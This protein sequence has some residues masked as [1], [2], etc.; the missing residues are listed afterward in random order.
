MANPSRRE[1]SEVRRVGLSAIS[2]RGHFCRS[3]G[4]PGDLPAFLVKSRRLILARLLNVKV[5]GDVQRH[6]R[7]T[8]ATQAF[9]NADRPERTKPRE[10]G[11]FQLRGGCVDL[12]ICLF[13]KKVKSRRLILAR[14]WNVKVWGDVQRRERFTG[15]R[16]AFGNADRPE[17]TKPRE[18][19][20]FQLRK[21]V[22]ARV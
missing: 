12:G 9:C 8:G 2:R 5:W 11:R 1:W 6:E 14:L 18:V 21:V 13:G 22:C 3:G 15:A 16:R 7:F 19:G 20:R 4:L 10:V 17:R